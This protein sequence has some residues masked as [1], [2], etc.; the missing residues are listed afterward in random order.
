MTSRK[1]LATLLLV[2]LVLG[3]AFWIDQPVARLM[4]GNDPGIVKI[5]A[6]VT[7]FGQ[8]GYILY[9]SGAMVLAALALRLLRPVWIE[10][11]DKVARQTAFIFASV[12]AAGLAVDLAKIAFGRARPPLWLAGDDSGF[13]FLR[14]GWK[15]NSFPSG[16]TAT[17]FAA[18]IAFSALF[19][20]WRG[21]FF[22]FAILIAASRLALNLHYLSDVAAGA[23]L[24]IF[25]AIPI[26]ERA[27]QEGWLL[28]AP[29][30]ES[31]LPTVRRRGVVPKTH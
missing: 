17:S 6:F 25:I 7:R 11:L 27:R 29:A 30:Q 12:A 14:Y 19:P 4:A 18:A 9:P 26:R 10:T 2:L 5:A 31:D 21:V 3:T 8:G 13:S 22:T 20:R 16:H 1:T 28:R 24:G 23:I 15:F